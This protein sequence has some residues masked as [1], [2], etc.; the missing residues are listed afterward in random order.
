[1]L[2]GT[3]T[4]PKCSYEFILADS[5]FDVVTEQQ[6]LLSIEGQI[7]T[8]DGE[9]ADSKANVTAIETEEKSI[10]KSRKESLNEENRWMDRLNA[11]KREAQRYADDL[12]ELERQQSDLNS[13]IVSL[14]S[15]SDSIRRKI[16][17]EAFEM[18]DRLYATNDRDVKRCREEI[19]AL[20]SSI[21]TLQSTKLE[22][23]NSSPDEVLTKLK[24]SLKE[25]RTKSNDLFKQCEQTK[26]KLSRLTTQQ[27]RFSDFRSYLANTKIAALSTITNEFLDSIGSDIRIH[28]S[29]YTKLKSGKIR[30]KISVSLVRD[31][32]DCGSFGKFS[33]GERARVN[34]STI[35]A[36]QKLINSN[37]EDDKGLDLLVLDE[38]LSAV[39]EEGNSMMFESL[40]KL[41]ITSLVVSHGYVSESYP[42]TLIIRKENGESKIS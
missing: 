12:T 1:M 2:A 10:E 8:V 24:A 5:D 21:E 29:G 34:L 16:F 30:E 38:I 36:M 37:C 20:N 11:A 9:I 31:G 18:V 23:E 4:C 27:Q 17:D 39:D 22:I 14:Q 25:Y 6:N 42:H 40:N 19:A 28:F 35:L 3:I 13:K 15:S 7:A 33:E 41:G 26:E 32:V